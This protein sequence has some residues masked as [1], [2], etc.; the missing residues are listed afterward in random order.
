M[1][2]E[3]AACA[4]TLALSQRG[5]NHAVWQ[6]A[7]VCATCSGK[8]KPAPAQRGRWNFREPPGR[9]LEPMR[10]RR[11]IRIAVAPWATNRKQTGVVA[12]A[13]F[14]QYVERP[15]ST[16]H[17]REA[18]RP[19]AQYRLTGDFFQDVFGPSNRLPEHERGLRRNARVI[20]PVRCDLVTC[21]RDGANQRGLALRH[22]PEDKERRPGVMSSEQVEQRRHLGRHARFKA[23]PVGPG[24]AGL[25]CRDLEVF[26]DVDREVVRDH[27]CARRRVTSDRC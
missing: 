9:A 7:E 21:A 10:I 3:R 17:D 1:Y 19:K 5:P 15:L 24:D 13:F 20:P 6:Q 18:R 2:V 16:R 12:I 14:D 23:F 22:P 8:T 11:C 4:A 27:S 25:E 26:L